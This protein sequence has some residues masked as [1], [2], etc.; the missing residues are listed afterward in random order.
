MAISSG[1]S[2][3]GCPPYPPPCTAEPTRPRPSLRM[4]GLLERA[5]SRASTLAVRSTTLSVATRSSESIVRLPA[6]PS[7]PT[8]A[9]ENRTIPELASMEALTSFRAT[10]RTTSASASDAP[11]SRPTCLAMSSR[12]TATKQ[13]VSLRIRRSVRAC[14]ACRASPRFLSLTSWAW[15]SLVSTS[16]LSALRSS[17]WN[18]AARAS[19]PR[20]PWL[21]LRCRTT[22]PAV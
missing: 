9:S 5:M 16:R 21:C 1:Y 10:M 15:K 6:E 22:H 14:T 18:L 7:N 17:S 2:S 12:E 4:A 13:V 3:L 11:P 19:Y 8:A 20:T